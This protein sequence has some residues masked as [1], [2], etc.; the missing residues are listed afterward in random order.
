VG[1]GANKHLRKPGD[2]SNEDNQRDHIDFN[3]S[4]VDL[5][6]DNNEVNIK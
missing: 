1:K 2:E 4:T 3:D 5:E 6:E